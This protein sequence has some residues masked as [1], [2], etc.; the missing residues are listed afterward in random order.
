M[1]KKTPRSAKKIVKRLSDFVK[2][3]NGFISKE[4][5]LKIGI[6]T[7][8]VLGVAS[9]AFALECASQPANVNQQ[10]LNPAWINTK[11]YKLQICHQN[12]SSHA[13]HGSY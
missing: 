5:I 4:N 8:S 1:H 13:S 6:G 3:E 9:S 7:I 12:H 11:C 2:D 10:I